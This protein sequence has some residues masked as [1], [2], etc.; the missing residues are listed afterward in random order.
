MENKNTYLNAE[1]RPWGASENRW[2]QGL[3]MAA[4]VAYLD[5][6]YEL[7]RRVNAGEGF[8]INHTDF[9]AGPDGAHIRGNMDY[10]NDIAPYLG[11]G[12]APKIN[13]NWGVFGEV[14][15][16]YAD[17]PDVN[18]QL[19]SGGAA[20][21]PTRGSLVDNIAADENKIATDDKHKWLPVGKIGVSY[22]W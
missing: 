5:N 8:T 16:Y 7:D 19:V 12:W 1:I 4:G 18:L 6:E 21:N 3:Y 11:F 20:D 17:N 15:A 14:G 2:V 22:H 10:K 13:K 9:V